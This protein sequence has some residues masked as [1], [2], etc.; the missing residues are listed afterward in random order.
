[1]GYNL[2]I[3]TI[4]YQETKCQIEKLK[5]GGLET[6][7]GK[8][9]LLDSPFPGG[10]FF[11]YLEDLSRLICWLTLYEQMNLGD[12]LMRDFAGIGFA[13]LVGVR[14]YRLTREYNVRSLNEAGG[15]GFINILA[16]S[17]LAIAA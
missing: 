5:I 6:E 14:N 15:S 17:V 2:D 9:E 12:T 10:I 4:S 13:P 16:I 11:E 1:M 7:K 3:W 8:S